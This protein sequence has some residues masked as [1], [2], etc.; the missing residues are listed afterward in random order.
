MANQK[1][2]SLEI[3]YSGGAVPDFH[4]CSLFVGSQARAT[5]HQHISSGGD[6]TFLLEEVQSLAFRGNRSHEG[7]SRDQRN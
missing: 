2:V 5:N 1:W 3:G 7:I 6:L 4:R